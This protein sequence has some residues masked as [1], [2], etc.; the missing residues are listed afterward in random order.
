MNL[1]IIGCG[2]IGSDV[3]KAA[4]RMREIKKIYLY[5]RDKKAADTLC[6]L[7]RKAEVRKVEDF[8]EDVDVVFEAA[9][10]QAV[11]EYGLKV[12][13]AGKDL[14]IMSIGSLFDDQLRKKLENTA[15]RK[16]CR[17]YLPSGAVCGI[18]GILAASIEKI[19]SVTL[20]TTKPPSSLGR[21]LNKRTVVFDGNAREAVK[22]F[23]R[24]INVAA[25][26]SLAGIGF[27]RT[28]VKIVADP[29][30]N[31]I[32]HKILAHGRFGRLRAEM[33]NLPNPN[34]PQS[35][36][37]ASLSAIAILKR[38]VDPIQIGA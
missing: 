24:N 36:Y 11:V 29:V 27:D 37:M 32:S 10:Q 7:L 2:A 28:R 21:R 25:C 12:L 5:D 30:V 6:R 16:R 38:I 22:K 15:R 20:V 33:E 19:D 18:D 13:R 3:A 1:G 17:I 4:D 31:R 34:N 35:S 23:P 9:S 26:L 8:I 14:I